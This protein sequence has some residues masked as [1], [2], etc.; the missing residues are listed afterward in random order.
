MLY[1]VFIRTPVEYVL[2]ILPSRDISIS[3]LVPRV[4][5]LASLYYTL[6]VNLEVSILARGARVELSGVLAW[7]SLFFIDIHEDIH[8][9]TNS[10]DPFDTF[11]RERRIFPGSVIVAFYSLIKSTCIFLP[12]LSNIVRF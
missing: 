4:Y 2:V 7:I 5:M 9:S 11:V 1:E 6:A 12:I 3:C 10:K 8:P